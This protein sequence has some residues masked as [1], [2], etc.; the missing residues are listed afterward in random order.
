[1]RKLWYLFVLVLGT[2]IGLPATAVATPP[3]TGHFPIEEHI[4][5]LEPESSVCG[6][7]ISLDISGQGTFQVFFD[8]DGNPTGAHVT[9]V[10]SGELSAN[11]ITLVTRSADNL[12]FDFTEN[13]V[14]ETGL[15]FQ[16]Q[17]PGTGVVLMDRG[18][19]V[20]NI[21]PETGEMIGEPVFELEDHARRTLTTSI[22]DPP[23]DRCQG[24]CGGGAADDSSSSV[25]FRSSDTGRWPSH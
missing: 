4:A 22:E 5:V 3:E 6:F 24:I 15:V 20:W 13:T 16:Y 18:R 8:A 25:L 7:P 2:M 23:L 17:L 1:M 11:G 12:H 14:V 21:D 9:E 19:L 10:I